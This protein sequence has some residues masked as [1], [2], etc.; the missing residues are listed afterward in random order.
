[1]PNEL[2][3]MIL[4]GSR[5]MSAHDTS[6]SDYF[7]R[8]RHKS[9]QLF[10]CRR[11]RPNLIVKIEIV[12]WLIGWNTEAE[13]STSFWFR[14]ILSWVFLIHSVLMQGNHA[15][16]VQMVLLFLVKSEES[17]IRTSEV[18]SPLMIVLSMSMSFRTNQKIV[19]LL[20]NF[21]VAGQPVLHRMLRKS[22]TRNGWNHLR[23][24]NSLGQSLYTEKGWEVVATVH[25]ST[26][27]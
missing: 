8:S 22:R 2:L 19:S 13:G 24:F 5:K 1:M 11:S 3:Y 17:D 14:S 15:Y 9:H 16:F 25:Y 4:A 12:N 26:F 23:T 21:V 6:I 10:C 7:S 27:F 20:W 18:P